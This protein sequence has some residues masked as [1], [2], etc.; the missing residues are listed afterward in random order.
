MATQPPRMLPTE[1]AHDLLELASEL[2]DKELAP[3]VDEYERRGEFP[4]EVIRT[5]GRAGLLGLPYPSE[6]GG[7]EQPYEVYLQVLEVLASRWLA[8]AE[9][10]SVHTLAC[11]PLAAHGDD[12]QREQ[13]L[14][15]M[16]GGEL[17]GAYCLS[18]P[19]GGSDAAAMTTRGIRDGDGYRIRGTKAWI[20]HAGVAD[21]Y[22]VFCRTGDD[23]P[24][25]ISCLLVDA[26]T[27]GVEPQ[28]RERTMGIQSSPVAQIVFDDA[29]VPAGRLLGGEGR[30][31][32]IAMQALDAGRLGIAACAVGLAQAALDYAVSYAQER[33]QF[34]QPIIDFQGVGFLL[35]D[36]ATQI[37]AA[38]ALTLAAARLKDA[39]LPFSSEAAKAKLFATDMAMRVTTDA[40]QVLGGYGYVA[41]HPVERWMREAKIL[42]IV[43]GTNQI[44]RVVISRALTRD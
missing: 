20:T 16:L 2:A 15:E 23:G 22:N 43:E 4:R 1:D 37:S 28:P 31:F 25:G 10:V 42:Q 8:V 38:R 34:G 27:A 26:D 19:A 33:R 17:L 5:I 35:A 30:G 21:F 29:P 13:F 41:D 6:Y 12:A 3:K 14:S 7:A 32:A 36:A 18:E 44:Q 9:A 39:G 24:A 11:Y 40:V